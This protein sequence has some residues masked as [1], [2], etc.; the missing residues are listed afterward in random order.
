M[1]DETD[2]PGNVPAQKGSL[3]Y[4]TRDTEVSYWQPEPANGYTTVAV[5][6]QLFKMN[7][8][9]SMGTQTLP[10][11]GRV[12]EHAHQ[13]NEEVLH[14][15]SGTGTAIVEG[16]EYKLEPGVTLFL[17]PHNSHT[18]TNDGDV[19]LHW[20]WGQCLEQLVY[21]CTGEL[22]LL[23]PKFSPRRVEAK[24]YSGVFGAEKKAPSVL[25]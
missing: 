8:D 22:L 21:L 17:G 25:R 1:N 9:F 4:S 10:L 5:S 13:A 19:E 24:C 18:L 20:V 7:R 2:T 12:R 15:V 3:V 16:K 11:G 6:P 14:F 23:G